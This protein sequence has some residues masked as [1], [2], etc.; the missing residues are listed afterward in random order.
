M[1]TTKVAE[2]TTIVYT[3]SINVEECLRVAAMGDAPLITCR[4][5]LTLV[6]ILQTD[7]AT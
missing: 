5:S 6:R 2:H 7:L 4:T 3:L 1:T